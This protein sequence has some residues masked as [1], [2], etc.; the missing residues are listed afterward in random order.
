MSTHHLLIIP[1]SS[2]RSHIRYTPCP[3]NHSVPTLSTRTSIITVALLSVRTMPQS[4][5]LDH[6]I[7]PTHGTHHASIISAP[8]STHQA[9]IATVSTQ[10]LHSFPQSS[11]RSH[12]RYTSCLNY[13]SVPTLSNIMLQSSQYPHTLYTSGHN[14]YSVPIPYTHNVSIIILYPHHVYIM[15]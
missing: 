15:P 6:H 1:Q 9:S 3:N 2:Q 14:H 11:Q 12:T 8:H 7:A 13:H 5:C 4:S 10:P